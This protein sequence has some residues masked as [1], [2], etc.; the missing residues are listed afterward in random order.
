MLKFPYGIS[1]FYKLRTE[2]YVYVDRTQYIP[3]TMSLS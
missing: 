1:D 2:G 3:Y